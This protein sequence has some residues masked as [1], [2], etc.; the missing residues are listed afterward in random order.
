MVMQLKLDDCLWN[1]ENGFDPDFI[2]EYQGDLFA[3]GIFSFYLLSVFRLP[4]LASNILFRSLFFD[5]VYIELILQTLCSMLK[6]LD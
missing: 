1:P 3:F 4:I 6:L 2:D 5:F